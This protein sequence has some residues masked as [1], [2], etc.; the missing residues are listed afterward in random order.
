MSFGA[1]MPFTTNSLWLMCH[2]RCVHHRPPHRRPHGHSQ[3]GH[4]HRPP[5][6]TAYT[7][8]GDFKTD[9]L[10]FC[11]IWGLPVHPQL[12]KSWK[13]IQYEAGE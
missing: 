8:S 6:A 4:L 9:Y 11:K 13:T 12:V 10:A 3:H 1:D 2:Q 5:V 7:P